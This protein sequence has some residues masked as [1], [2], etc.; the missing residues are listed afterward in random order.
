MIT[1]IEWLQAVYVKKQL[2]E[3]AIDNKLIKRKATFI[4]KLLG[5]NDYY[6]ASSNTSSDEETEDPYLH[7]IHK[8]RIRAKELEIEE[9]INT[10][11]EAKLMGN[12]LYRNF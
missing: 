11:I 5:N 12:P 6:E 3:K 4:G 2:L 1:N 10:R 9:K 7:K 8:E